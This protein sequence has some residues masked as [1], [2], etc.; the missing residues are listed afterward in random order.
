MHGL[1]MLRRDQ[2]K[3]EILA[4]VKSGGLDEA[5]LDKLVL[6]SWPRGEKI[7]HKD[8]KLRTFIAQEKGRNQMVSHVY[9]VTFGQIQAGRTS[10]SSTTRSSAAR[11]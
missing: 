5:T 8:I 11:P 7:A 6:K 3:E 4:A 10:S 1:R 2:V 9:D